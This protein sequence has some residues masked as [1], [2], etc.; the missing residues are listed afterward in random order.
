MLSDLDPRSVIGSQKIKVVFAINSVKI[1]VQS[2]HKLKSKQAVR[3]ATR[4]APAP[5]LPLC[6][7]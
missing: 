4:Y 7:F 3:V 6:Q 2:R 1:V 5:L